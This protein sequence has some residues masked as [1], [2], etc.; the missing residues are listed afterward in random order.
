VTYSIGISR[1]S[2]GSEN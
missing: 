1:F 2:D